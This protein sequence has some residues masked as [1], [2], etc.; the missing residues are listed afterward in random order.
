MQCPITKQTHRHPLRLDRDQASVRPDPHKHRLGRKAGGLHGEICHSAGWKNNRRLC[1]HLHPRTGCTCRFPR[2]SQGISD[3]LDEDG[4]NDHRGSSYHHPSTAPS[5][6]HID[7][8]SAIHTM[9]Q[10]MAPIASRVGYCGAL[11]G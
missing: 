2:T 5:D 9:H 4:G 8:R 11:A 6:I 10:I 3:K 1:R 7:S